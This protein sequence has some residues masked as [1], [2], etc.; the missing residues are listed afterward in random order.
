MVPL[1]PTIG[2]PLK[3]V[4]IVRAISLVAYPDLNIDVLL[5]SRGLI[6]VWLSSTRLTA[7]VPSPWP[8]SPWQVMQ[9]SLVNSALPSA[10]V[11][12]LRAGGAPRVITVLRSSL[13]S[14]KRGEKVLRYST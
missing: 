2:V 10:T 11:A 7:A 9:A 1:K 14:A 8:A 5:K 6:L 12:S 13:V 3:P 4:R